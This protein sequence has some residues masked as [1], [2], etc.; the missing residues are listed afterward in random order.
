MLTLETAR[1]WYPDFDSVHG[2]DHIERVYGMCE[3]IGPKEG[4]DMQIVRAAALLHDAQGSHPKKGQRKNHHIE[5]A[6]FAEQILR[7]EGWE[8]PAI[9]AV[10]HCIISHRFRKNSPPET[11]EA[12]VLFDADKLDVIGAIGIVR[13]LAFANQVQQ[14]AYAPP[15]AQFLQSGKKIAGEGHSAYHEYIFKLKHIA[16]LL[17]TDSARH[18]AAHRQAFINQFFEELKK[19]NEIVGNERN[20]I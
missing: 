13:A 2:F 12:K 18:I 4:A 5:S 9:M 1:A 15:S 19:E 10:Q 8:Q 14:P 20:L 16:S 3:I 11:I 7:E 6:Q 17:F